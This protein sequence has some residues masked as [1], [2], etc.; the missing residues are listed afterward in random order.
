VQCDSGQ[1]TSFR[2]ST[3]SPARAAS[4]ALTPLDGVEFSYSNFKQ[5][6]DM[7]VRSRGS[8]RPSFVSASPSKMEGAGKAGCWPHP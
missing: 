7:R 2:R 6:K 3:P 5:P 4:L 1:G 8:N